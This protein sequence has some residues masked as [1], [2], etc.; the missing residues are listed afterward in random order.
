MERDA[1]EELYAY[2]GFQWDRLA[3]VME[4]LPSEDFTKAVEGSGWPSLQKAFIHVLYAYDD[5]INHEEWGLGLGKSSVQD[6]DSWD[7]LYQRIAT[8][9]DVKAFRE[10]TRANFREALEVPDEELFAKRTW[11]LE[12]G[13]E[14]L[15]R[16]DVLTNLLVHEI[17]HRGDISTL[18]HQ[19][20][21]K[22]LLLDYRF[23]ISK[24][25]DYL[26]DTD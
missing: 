7:E 2:T 10:A 26:P 24:P 11:E 8:W 13:P 22:H 20:G 6:V 1:I 15:T 12:F 9:D 19:L 5:W 25:N 16:A 23:F 4:S 18:F 21:L 17:A 3:R 14:E